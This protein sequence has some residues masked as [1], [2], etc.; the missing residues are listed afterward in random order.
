M[1]VILHH[2]TL[3]DFFTARFDEHGG[4]QLISATKEGV[5][6]RRRGCAPHFFGWK[7]WFA[8]PAHHENGLQAI[9]APNARAGGSA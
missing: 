5:T 9:I 2:G 3:L 8:M 6:A 4:W 1:T 7:E